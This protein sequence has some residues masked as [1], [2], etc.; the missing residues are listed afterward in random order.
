M[1]DSD[2]IATAIETIEGNVSDV[3]EISVKVDKTETVVVTQIDSEEPS[4]DDALSINNE[5]NEMS[6]D[7]SR[8]DENG[9]LFQQTYKVLLN[10]VLE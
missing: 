9:E 5:T 1:I 3:V 2:A 10:S 7:F 6:F 8:E 4:A